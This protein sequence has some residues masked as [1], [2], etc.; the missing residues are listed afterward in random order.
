MPT[1]PKI[2][3]SHAW[4][5][6]ALVRRLEAE[7]QSAGG[8]VWVDHSGVRGGDNL[9]KRISEAL[10]WCDTVLLIWSEAASRSHWVEMEWTNAVSLRKTIIPCL[11]S[12]APLPAMLANVLYVDCCDFG[13]GLTQLCQA[14]H[15]KPP[16]AALPIMQLPIEKLLDQVIA[17]VVK[18]RRIDAAVPSAAEVG[19]P[20]DLRVQVRF[21]DSP[22]LGLEDWPAKTKPSHLEQASE[23]VALEFSIDAATGK[24]G[25]ARLEIHVV[26]PD[27]DLAGQARQLLLV[28]PDWVSKCLSFLLTPKKTGVCR[29]NVEVYN[30]EHIFLGAIPIETEVGGNDKLQ[31]TNVANLFL[32]VMVGKERTATRTIELDDT[33]EKLPS[34][35]VEPRAQPTPGPVTPK[36]KVGSPQAI[37][38]DNV[39]S[40]APPKSSSYLPRAAL[41]LGLLASLV[42]VLVFIFEVPKKLLKQSSDNQEKPSAMIMDLAGISDVKVLQEKLMEYERSMLIAI[43]SK[44]DFESPDD[45]YVFVVDESQV[46][47]VYKFENNFFYDLK[48]EEKL[49]DLSERFAGKAAIWVKDHSVFGK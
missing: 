43:G 44:E 5:D 47:G 24:L 16:S 21:P 9:P 38:K 7:L 10:A 22:L 4:E 37:R 17:A 39:Y 26:A 42:T 28:P 33:V 30:V 20:I 35:V 13:N 11:L 29:L 15:L 46:L 36:P 41:W 19:R 45:C 12:Q 27:F 25:S 49:S 34:S 1:T 8:E 23:N 2:F 3:I 14:L 48:S 32:F 40:E 6:K 18:E 31:T